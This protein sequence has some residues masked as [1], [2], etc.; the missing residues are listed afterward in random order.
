MIAETPVHTISISAAFLRSR[1]TTSAAGAQRGDGRIERV[2]SRI[3]QS[4]ER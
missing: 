2:A 3:F 1:L 4:P